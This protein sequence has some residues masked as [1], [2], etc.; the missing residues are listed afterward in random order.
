MIWGDDLDRAS[1]H[2]VQLIRRI[3]PTGRSQR[4]FVG[5]ELVSKLNKIELRLA[6]S[7]E[8]R[9]FSLPKGRGSQEVNIAAT[10]EHVIRASR[11]VASRVT[12]PRRTNSKT[13]ATPNHRHLAPNT[14][15]PTSDVRA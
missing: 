6:L 15:V 13:L 3:P 14:P 2:A 5:F 11:P 10:G 1:N 7:S 8:C 9:G 4:G 12:Q